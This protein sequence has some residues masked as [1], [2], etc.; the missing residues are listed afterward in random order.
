MIYKKIWIDVQYVTASKQIIGFGEMMVV[1][2][3][4]AVLWSATLHRTHNEP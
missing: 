1:L 3:N 2:K 4:P